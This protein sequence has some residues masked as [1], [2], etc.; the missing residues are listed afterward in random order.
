[1]SE[2]EYRIIT[3]NGGNYILYEDVKSALKLQELVKDRIKK[4]DEWMEPHDDEWSHWYDTKKELQSLV[5]ESE[6]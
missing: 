5:E 3:S 2:R 1:M 6:K 4:C